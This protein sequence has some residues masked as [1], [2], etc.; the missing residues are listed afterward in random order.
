MKSNGLSNRTLTAVGAPGHRCLAVFQ[1]NK[2]R[3]QEGL[4]TQVATFHYV[5]SSPAWFSFATPLYYNATD[6]S[7]PVPIVSN[8]LPRHCC[9]GVRNSIKWSFTKYKPNSGGLHCQLH[10]LLRC[11]HPPAVM[12]QRKSDVFISSNLRT[13]YRLDLLNYKKNVP[14]GQKSAA[15]TQQHTKLYT[16]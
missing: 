14:P 6:T 10:R 16:R 7:Q 3:C 12:G 4:A 2:K 11:S 1:K 9:A 8:P 5:T 15:G 13:A